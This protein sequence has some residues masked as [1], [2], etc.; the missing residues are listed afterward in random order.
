MAEHVLTMRKATS[1]ILSIENKM[2]E[3][4][5]EQ[6][7]CVPHLRK[8]WHTSAL[9]VLVAQRR[10]VLPTVLSSISASGRSDLE[11]PLLS[12]FIKDYT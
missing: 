2:G 11:P 3:S 5:C 4:F 6:Q 7:L 8:L 10:D 12:F 1:S 9:H